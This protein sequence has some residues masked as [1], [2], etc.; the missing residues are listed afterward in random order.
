MPAL[1]YEKALAEI[2]ALDK[3][4]SHLGLERISR[5]LSLLGNPE[6]N[7]RCIIVAGSNGKGST[8]ELL[9]SCL[10]K[11]GWK[12]GTYFSPQVEEFSERMR[13]NGR[14]ADKK[15]ITEA[16]LQVRKVV[17]KNSIQATFFEVVTAMALL[18]FSDR[19]VKVAV[20]EAGL[21][22]RLDATN[23][24]EPEVSAIA[25]ISLEHTEVL[26][27]TQEAIVIEKCG[28]ARKGR[29]LVVGQVN[30]AVHMAI[31]EECKKI[32]AKPVFISDEAK[33]MRLK[34][35]DLR[36]SFRA[37]FNRSRYSVSLSA[38]G[39]FQVSNAL[40]ALAAA[41]L[42]GAKREAIE[43][44]LAGSAPAY[45]L[46]AMQRHPLTIA[47]CC[48]NPGAAF[49]I[50]SELRQLP[51]KKVLLFSAMSDKDY[52]QVLDILRPF[53]SQLVLTKVSLP[54]AAELGELEA[55]AVRAGFM[56]IV[57]RSPVAALTAAKR[58]AGGSGTVVIAGS[59]YLL[60]E[61]FGRDKIRIAQ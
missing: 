7:Y 31:E 34:S 17:S 57:V 24:V 20:L 15:D 35:K 25:S 53:F 42:M 61:L 5:I 59:I 29:P 3:F 47:D 28:I 50:A 19:K 8:V 9:G 10:A 54:R 33:V 39:K 13:I 41:S 43:K 16:Y 36:Y 52:A 40:V 11:N 55:A 27:N 30:G 51:G 2:Y 58:L 60:A 37:S 14:N 18:I 1:S 46:Q 4:G 6:K 49:A 38:P 48:H 12:V 56:P 21:G 45:R 44:G 32:G 22:G 23:A 26:G